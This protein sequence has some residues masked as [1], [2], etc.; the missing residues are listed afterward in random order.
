ML[1]FHCPHVIKRACYSTVPLSFTKF[2]T[3]KSHNKPAGVVEKKEPLV[4]CHGLFG[5]KQNWKLLAKTLSIKTQCKV[6]TLDARN[7]GESPHVEE[8]TYDSMADDVLQFLGE[9]GIKKPILMGHSMGAKVMMTLALRRPEIASKL[10]AIDMAPIQIKLSGEYNKHVE[11]MREINRL[12]L[13]K[14]KDAD[15]ILEGYET[16]LVVRQFLLTNLKKNLSKDGIYEFR[17]PYD[18]LGRSIDGLGDFFQLQ[19]T[20][21]YQGS[22]LFITGSLSPYR[23]EFIEQPDLI[24]A[25]FPHS[26]IV[27]IEGAGHWGRYNKSY[28]KRRGI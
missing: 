7:H 16:D 14:Q 3:Y 10:I 1:S 4:I 21:K 13:K 28:S 17:I 2:D 25:Q 20:V 27:N 6:Y 22:T 11:A 9:Q 18:I 15:K 19:P 8:H 24:K 26:R 5:S 23:R 12:K